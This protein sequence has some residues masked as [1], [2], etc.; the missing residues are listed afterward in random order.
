MKVAITGGTGYVGP[1][2]VKAMLAR[3]HDLVV[4]EH[5]RPVPV[6]DH[7]RLRRVKGDIRDR[8]SLEAAFAGADAVAHLVAILRESPRKGVTF[9][10]V[11]V[12]GTRNVVEAAKAAGVRRFLQMTANGCEARDTPYFETKWQMEQM[13]K[14]AGFEWTIFRPSYVSGTG[15]PGVDGKTATRGTDDSFDE[16][17]ARIVDVNPILPS[18]SGGRFEI[19]PIA[20]NDVAEAF[21][22]ALD[23]PASIGKTYI[24]VGPERMTWNEYLRRLAR[25]RGK[26]RA[27][28]Y[29]PTRLVQG[30]LRL[31]P[32]LPATS[33]Q[34]KMLVRGSVG[35]PGPVVRDLG[36]TLTP[37]EDAV[38]ALRKA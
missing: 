18:F 36:L 34:L 19:Q 7:P 28:V 32:F 11:H 16:Q 24:L 22:R 5:K 27:L 10:A 25:L 38:A 4:I 12:E 15:E 9:Q 31:A 14:A 2:I 29:A 13:V 37:W 8:A 6:P 1:A 20:R 21:A 23:A 33:D 35:D 3:G 26:R 17:F 30:V